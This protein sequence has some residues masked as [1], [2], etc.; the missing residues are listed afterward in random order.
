[1][2]HEVARHVQ[3]NAKLKALQRTPHHLII[4]RI[5]EL[6]AHLHQRAPMEIKA[7]DDQVCCTSS[8]NLG[9]SLLA[10]S[11]GLACRIS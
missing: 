7:A 2:S 1:M 4:A 11:D 10:A 8:A 3:R 5:K 6:L 9:S